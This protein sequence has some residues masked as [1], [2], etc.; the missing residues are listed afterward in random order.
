MSTPPQSPQPA[1]QPAPQPQQPAPAVPPQPTAYPY[2]NPQSPPGN[3]YAQPT[4]VGGPAAQPQ[5]GQPGQFGQGQ[6]GQP[7]QFGQPTQPQPGNPY[8]QAPQFGAA[9]PPVP[10]SGGG[11][12]G[13]AVL[14]AAV[15]AVVASAAWAG[16]VFLLGGKG[17]SADL[18]GYS[19]P[20]NMCSSA[21]YS[22]FKDEY[23]QGD[24]SP[25]KTSL[26]NVAL[27]ESF[28]SVGLKKTGST[29]ADAY[30]SMQ[31]DLHRKTNPGPEF[32]A[33]WKN[34]GDSHTGYDVSPVSGIGD[35]AY[36]VSQ[37]TTSGSS[38][39]G[40]RYATLAV[41]D[42]WVTYT[43]SYSAYLT[44]YDQDKNPPALS[45]VD[46]WLKKDAKATLGQLK[47]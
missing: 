22:S 31:L 15:G 12:V 16:G 27:D 18:R 26:K 17:G 24:S 9:V 19:A 4:L 1:D 43:M 32:T 46:D 25:T 5:P 29:Y 7:G 28:C 8:A 23:P 20:S 11:A 34:Y 36:L 10:A 13:K 14:W 30:L 6:P 3:F 47:N 33:T 21:D 35:E 37:D 38:S 44:S 40:S 41:R 2:P 42:G 39:S 45:D